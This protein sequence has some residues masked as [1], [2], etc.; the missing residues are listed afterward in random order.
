M[1]SITKDQFKS[2]VKTGEVY[3][4]ILVDVD[5]H[6]WSSY[7]YIVEIDK[8]AIDE[9]GV[10]PDLLGTFWSMEVNIQPEWGIEWSMCY[11]PPEQV[12]R[13]E[14]TKVEWVVV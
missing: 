6:G 7:Q 9:L 14:V 13:K 3:D 4:E 12:E 2:I 8:F 11:Y 10:D 1:A 5:D